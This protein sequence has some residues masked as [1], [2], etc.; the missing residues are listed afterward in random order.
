M[1]ISYRMA[2]PLSGLY[3]FI[4]TWVVLGCSANLL[5]YLSVASILF[6]TQSPHGKTCTFINFEKHSSKMLELE[7]QQFI[8]SAMHNRGP[9]IVLQWSLKSWKNFSIDR[10]MNA[11]A[12]L[13]Y[14]I[15]Q[16][17]RS[18][19]Q[20]IKTSMVFSLKALCSAPLRFALMFEMIQKRLFWWTLR[21]GKTVQVLAHSASKHF[22]IFSA[23]EPL[24][25]IMD[26]RFF[27]FSN[28]YA[29][30]IRLFVC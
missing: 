3:F 10:L 24:K 4:S 19:L 13:F 11:D 29:N 16:Y 26:A 25:S 30:I 20:W 8:A 12:L 14:K 28:L 6:H 9:F 7:D 2:L 22:A 15:S 23:K 21:M 17:R 27:F 1:K 18:F 5:Y